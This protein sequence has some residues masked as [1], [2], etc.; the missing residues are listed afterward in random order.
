M[1]SYKKEIQVFRKNRGI[2]RTMEAIKSGISPR[3]LYG[4]RD[5]GII[6]EL[7]RGLYKL[8]SDAY[9]SNPDFVIVGMRIPQGVICLLSALAYHNITTHIPNKIDIALKKGAS[10]PR[11]RYPPID[12]YWFSE[13][14]FIAGVETHTI[15]KKQIKIYSPEKTVADCFK[16]RKRIGLDTAVEALKLCRSRKRSEISTIMKYAEICR[17]ANVIQPY[18]EA[19]S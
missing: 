1:K 12:Y 13:H 6:Q 8:T 18:L 15:D 10:K 2:L 4:M 3:E 16:F 5:K 14:S 19:I 9:I 17:V 7:S 11:L